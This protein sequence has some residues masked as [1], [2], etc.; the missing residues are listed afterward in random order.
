MRSKLKAQFHSQLLCTV[1]KQHRGDGPVP[2]GCLPKNLLPSFFSD[3]HVY[4]LYLTFFPSLLTAC[5]SIFPLPK[6]IFTIEISSCTLPPILQKSWPLTSLTGALYPITIPLWE[7]LYLHPLLK[8]G[9]S[10]T[11]SNLDGKSWRL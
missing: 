7:L 11:I 1:S 10:Q 6:H 2:L 3:L 4:I 9:I 8:K 5:A